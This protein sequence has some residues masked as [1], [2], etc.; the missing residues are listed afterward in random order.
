MKLHQGR[1]T[2]PVYTCVPCREPGMPQQ[3]LWVN[4]KTIPSWAPSPAA[5][6]KHALATWAPLWLSSTVRQ[7]TLTLCNIARNMEPPP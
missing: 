1:S 4:H 3:H 2:D 7:R 5:P 6:P